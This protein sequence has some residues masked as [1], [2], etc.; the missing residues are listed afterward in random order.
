MVT[1]KKKSVAL[2]LLIVGTMGTVGLIDAMSTSAMPV[3]GKS[4]VSTRRQYRAKGKRAEEQ[5]Q[6]A[7]QRAEGQPSN[8]GKEHD[9]YATRHHRA[10]GQPRKTG[11]HSKYTTRHRGW[12][13]MSEPSKKWVAWGKVLSDDAKE[14]ILRDV[15]AK[16]ADHKEVVD[17]IVARKRAFRGSCAKDTIAECRAKLARSGHH[18]AKHSDYRGVR[19]TTH[20]EEKGRRTSKYP[21]MLGRTKGT[22]SGVVE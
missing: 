22:K 9:T 12:A 18:G 6:A 5:R 15:A 8:V 16:H 19:K 21:E 14:A 20:H 7:E 11:K 3:E 17:E 13:Y 1:N 4:S 10:E 2:A